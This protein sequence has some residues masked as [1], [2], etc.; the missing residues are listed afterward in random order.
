MKVLHLGQAIGGIDVY[1]RNICKYL[2]NDFEFVIIRGD[3]DNSKPFFNIDKQL[4]FEYKIPLYRRISIINDVKS[5]CQAI[6]IVKTEKPDIIHAHSAKGGLVG[7]IVGAVTGTKT[8]YTPHA[9]SFLSSKSWLIRWIYKLVER[10][11]RFKTILLACSESEKIMA[12]NQVGYKNGN[13]LV[14]SNSVPDASLTYN[15]NDKFNQSFVCTIG[16]PSYQKNTTF[17]IEVVKKVVQEIPDFKLFILGVGHHSPELDLVKKKIDSLSLHENVVLKP[18]VNQKE[19]FKYVSSSKFYIS[20]AKY[21]GLP[22]SIIEAMSL[23]KA[24]IASDVPGNVDCVKHD[25]NGFLLPLEVNV[26]AEKIID[27][28][29]DNDKRVNFGNHSRTIYTAQ[30]NI[31]LRIN[32]LE[33]IY[34]NLF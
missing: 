21:E 24:I 33:T 14:W 30:F 8:L 19:V 16:R 5:I 17:L 9:F 4:I 34:K 32:K 26:F 28:W 25:T 29:F 7:R 18:W 12:I 11:T 1:I 23:G 31:E 22:L 10:G 20:T 15:S 3:A 6:K 27:L 13:A 2:P